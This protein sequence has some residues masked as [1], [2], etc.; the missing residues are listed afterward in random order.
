MFDP[1]KRHFF[2]LFVKLEQEIICR[3]RVIHILQ[4]LRVIHVKAATI[5]KSFERGLDKYGLT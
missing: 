1:Q 5:S 4:S 3:V 2:C